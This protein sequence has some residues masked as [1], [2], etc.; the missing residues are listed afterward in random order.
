M[1]PCQPRC[2]RNSAQ[3]ASG[4]VAESPPTTAGSPRSGIWRA[5]TRELVC[6]SAA[7]AVRKEPTER[8]AASDWPASGRRT[9]LGSAMTA[10]E[11]GK[12]SPPSVGGGYAILTGRVTGVRARLGGLAGPCRPVAGRTLPCSAAMV[13]VVRVRGAWCVSGKP[14]GGGGGDG[15]TSREVSPVA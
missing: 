2:M 13:R 8:L 12:Q 4:T 6:T 14:A 11:R 15:V 1:S 10:G 9:R 3:L 7:W 5:H